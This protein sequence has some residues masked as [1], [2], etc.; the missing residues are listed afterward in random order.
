MFFTVCYRF[1]PKRKL[2]KKKKRNTINHNKILLAIT[3]IIRIIMTI[4]M[5]VFAMR[6]I[7]VD[8]EIMHYYS[9]GEMD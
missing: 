1:Y 7:H 5:S 2:K 3:P 9:N 4:V 8:K 6:K